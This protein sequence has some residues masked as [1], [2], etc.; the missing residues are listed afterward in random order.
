MLTRTYTQNG[1]QTKQ[2]LRRPLSQW[3]PT[4]E[5]AKVYQEHELDITWHVPDESCKKTAEE[6]IIK[7]VFP[8]LDKIAD[9]KTDR[10]SLRRYTNQLYY[11]YMGAY[12]CFPLPDSAKG[13]PLNPLPSSLPRVK[14]GPSAIPLIY[15]NMHHPTGQNVRE[16]IVDVC[17]KII[18]RFDNKKKDDCQVLTMLSALLKVVLSDTNV[19]QVYF[20][21]MCRFR[22]I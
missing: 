3:I 13:P 15:W 11:G 4:R 17:E 8:M 20:I 7:F 18:D 9:A 2:Q 21:Q 12:N 1:E 10:F 6:L 16:M 5:W 22:S 14:L 19:D